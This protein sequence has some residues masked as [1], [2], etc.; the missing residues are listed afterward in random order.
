MD[1][2]VIG[3]FKISRVTNNPGEETMMYADEY[4]RLRLPME[5]AKEL[6]FWDYYFTQGGARWGSGLIRYLS[7]DQVVRILTDLKDTIRDETAKAMIITLLNQD[8]PNISPPPAIGPRIQKSGNRTKRISMVRKY[9]PGGEG[10]EHK[11]LKEWIARNPEKIGLADVKRTEIE[12]TFISGDAADIVFELD[13]NRYAVVEIETIDSY[14]GSYQVLKYKVLKCAEL[15]M[16]IKCPEV[17]AIVVAWSIPQQVRDF[18]NKYGI[19]F[20]EKKL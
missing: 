20:V 7:D 15:G 5:E 17:E 2:K 10:I 16:D 8:F 12:H 19:R 11:R 6:Y 1:R 4:F 3:F 13:R 14:M 9:G 18:C